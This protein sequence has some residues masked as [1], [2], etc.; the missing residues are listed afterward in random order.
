MNLY[1]YLYLYLYL[2]LY[3]YLYLYLFLYLHL[4]LYLYFN[5]CKWAHTAGSR[6]KKEIASEMNCLEANVCRGPHCLVCICVSGLGSECARCPDIYLYLSE[7]VSVFV[8]ISVVMPVVVFVFVFVLVFVLVFVFVFVFLL[9]FDLHEGG[10]R[11][12][13]GL[14]DNL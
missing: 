3:F 10:K 7:F 9:V 14:Q 12:E 1:L 8:L 6:T 11:F 5:I 4:Y 13:N 2:H